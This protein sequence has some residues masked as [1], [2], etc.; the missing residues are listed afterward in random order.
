[1]GKLDEIF[2]KLNWLPI[3][4]LSHVRLY[5]S[6]RRCETSM[7]TKSAFMKTK[8]EKYDLCAQSELENLWLIKKKK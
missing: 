5:S 8:M 3:G 4:F 7:N 2:V 1:M 6:W